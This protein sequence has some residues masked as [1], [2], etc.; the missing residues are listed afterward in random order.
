MDRLFS[1][2]LETPGSGNVIRI[3]NTAT[4]EFPLTAGVES[5]NVNNEFS[6]FEP[7]MGEDSNEDFMG[8]DRIH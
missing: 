2:V 8:G 6:N 7:V 5:Y 3:V 1:M 4:V